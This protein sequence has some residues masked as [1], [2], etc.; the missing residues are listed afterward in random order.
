MFKF[1]NTSILKYK[2][3]RP[4][5]EISRPGASYIRCF[6]WN[7]AI[8]VVMKKYCMDRRQYKSRHLIPMFIGTP[9][10]IKQNHLF[11]FVWFWAVGWNPAVVHLPLFMFLLSS[12]FKYPAVVHLPLFIFLPSSRFK[13]TA[14]VHLPL[15]IFLLSRRFKYPAV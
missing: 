9:C 7:T 13:Y 2:N 3:V 11:R 8:I 1:S 4:H 6:N 15:F 5:F 10:I 14:V 12:R